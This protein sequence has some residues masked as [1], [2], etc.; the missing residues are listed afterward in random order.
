MFNIYFFLFLIIKEQ[1]HIYS[2]KKANDD[3]VLNNESAPV[4]MFTLTI[5]AKG[6]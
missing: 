1:F 4:W 6:F 5:L 2:S 3:S